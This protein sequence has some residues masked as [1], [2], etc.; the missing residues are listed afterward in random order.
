MV[1]KSSIVQLLKT[2]Y[3]STMSQT[4]NVEDYLRFLSLARKLRDQDKI[5]DLD[6]FEERVLNLL[7]S[8]WH[9]GEQITVLQAM[10][11][12]PDLSHTTVHRRLTTLKK[13]GLLQFNV[14]EQDG[15]V[16]YITPTNAANDYFSVL[17]E[18]LRK[19]RR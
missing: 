1:A 9:K 16:K 10:R 15:R 2:E 11:L 18:C 8:F 3:I 17:G 6:P 7:G 12:A 14:D 5:P 4:S 19:A 13:K